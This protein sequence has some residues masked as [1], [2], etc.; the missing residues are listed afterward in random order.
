M[1]REYISSSRPAILGMANR[2]AGSGEV[3]KDQD[4]KVVLKNQ[5]EDEYPVGKINS[6]T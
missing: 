6:S 2:L 3:P 4:L 5:E 1:C